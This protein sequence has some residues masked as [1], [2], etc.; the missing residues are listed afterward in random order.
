MN[1]FKTNR[2]AILLVVVLMLM[3]ACNDA[4]VPK[5]TIVSKISGITEIRR[6][7]AVSGGI[8]ISDK[9]IIARGICWSTNPNP[10][11]NDSLTIMENSNGNFTSKMTNLLP[12]TKYYVCAY[13]TNEIGTGYSDTLS[14]STLGGIWGK[15]VTDID[16]NEYH[17]ITIGTQTW[18]VE[19]LKT[20]KYRNGDLIGTTSPYNLDISQ[21]PAPKYQWA[22]DGNETNVENYGRLYSWYTITDL[23]NVA[24]IGWHVATYEDWMTLKYYLMENG[25]SSNYVK[26][27][28]SIAKSLAS[29]NLWKTTEYSSCVGNNQTT[30][31]NSD[32]NAVPS[33][34][35]NPEGTF[36]ELGI[37]AHWFA[38]EMS[39]SYA[40]K[41]SL[42]F[43]DDRYGITYGA[44]K[45]GVAVRCVKDK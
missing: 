1:Y 24:P 29:K 43:N 22:Y 23:R 25:Y 18:M 26:W 17:T 3:Y 5:L 39:Q 42:E 6:N 14:F 4:E 15:N 33:G 34:L 32:F 20:T 8:A 38:T 7:S 41:I 37:S 19:N 13:A 45:S 31:N 28:E 40:Y 10:T 44:N 12:A 11:I 27:D 2:Q 16:N 30:N 35:R 9:P 21:E 36:V